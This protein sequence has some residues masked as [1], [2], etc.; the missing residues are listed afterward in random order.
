MLK[1]QLTYKGSCKKLIHELQHFPSPV[2]TFALSLCCRQTR[3]K[4]KLGIEN[5]HLI[6]ASFL[7][8]RCGRSSIVT[9]QRLE[10][11]VTRH[12]R[13]VCVRPDRP[14]LAAAAPG[15]RRRC[16]SAVAALLIRRE[17]Y[18]VVIVFDLCDCAEDTI[19]IL[20]HSFFGKAEL[21]PWR[22]FA[23][24]GRAARHHARLIC[25]CITRFIILIG[26]SFLE[27]SISMMATFI[28]VLTSAISTNLCFVVLH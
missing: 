27:P 1:W 9:C 2:T 8:S 6:E 20:H 21:G 12:L 28:L 16:A 4:I 14:K 22:G 13:G 23:D 7:K 24:D 3:S 26:S 25:I 18:G 19:N 5:L 11:R 17:R 15:G 10:P